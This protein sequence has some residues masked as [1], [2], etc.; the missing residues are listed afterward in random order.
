[1]GAPR[2]AGGGGVALRRGHRACR[3][4]RLALYPRRRAA[5]R[6]GGQP[7]AGMRAGGGRSCRRAVRRARHSSLC[8]APG[9]SGPVCTRRGGRGRLPRL[10][11]GGPRPHPGAIFST[12]GRLD[13][14]LARVAER[15]FILTPT[16]RVQG[17]RP[18]VHL[19]SVLE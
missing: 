18:V 7:R 12:T 4:D 15:G 9:P 14:I 13:R 16:Y 3:G 19:Y 6:G 1:P 17:G 5:G 2:S 11:H 8:T 10:G